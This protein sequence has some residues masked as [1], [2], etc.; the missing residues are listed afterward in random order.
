M[1]HYKTFATTP[2]LILREVLPED[3]DGFFEL[4]SN[5]EVHRYLGNKP[6]TNRQTIHT[7]IEYI[8][9]QYIDYGIG[10]WAMVEKSSGKFIGWCGLKYVT[11]EINQHQNYYDLGYRLIESYWGK[12]LATEASKKAL[13]YGFKTLGLKVIYAAA[14]AEN[15]RSIRVLEHLGFHFVNKFKYDTEPN[16]WYKLETESWK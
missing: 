14:H 11:E 15:R 12:G 9:Q 1:I 2:R 4:D 16:N 10:R 5:P 7:V 8:R 3:E 13:D 6:V